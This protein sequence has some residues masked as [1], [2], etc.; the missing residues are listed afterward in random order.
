[1][2]VLQQSIEQILDTRKQ[3]SRVCV[4]DESTLLL[5]DNAFLPQDALQLMLERC[6][7]TEV[8]I[9]QC[10][11]SRSGYVVQFSLHD[12]TSLLL[13]RSSFYWWS[14]CWRV[15][16]CTLAVWWTSSLRGAGERAH[17]AALRS[18]CP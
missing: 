9:M 2:Q 10:E 3:G 15:S 8:S 14:A 5:Y 12:R 6:P 16:W 7:R 13:S 17:L 11:S 4:R 1:M 18:R